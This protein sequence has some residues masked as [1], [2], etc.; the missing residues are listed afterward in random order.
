MDRVAINRAL[1]KAMAYRACG[2]DA[3]ADAWAAE[4][5]RLL[6]SNRILDTDCV[7]ELL[8]QVRV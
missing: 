8:A 7:S 2:K 6:G 5:V 3:Q 1:A 4:L